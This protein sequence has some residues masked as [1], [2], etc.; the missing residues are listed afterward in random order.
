[1]VFP[2]KVL[3]YN[4]NTRRIAGTSTVSDQWVDGIAVT[5]DGRELL[6]GVPLH[7]VVWRFDA[8][9]LEFKGSIHTVF[10]VR[11]IAVDPERNLLLA[12]SLATNML[13]VIDLKTYER[14]AEYYISPWL[15]DICLDTKGGMAYVSSTE[16]LFRVHYTERLRRPKE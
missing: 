13:D 5:P 16:G 4:T 3:S 15:R 6:V 2:K 1:M 12:A 10:G 9:S 7:S 8:E 14:A 11:T